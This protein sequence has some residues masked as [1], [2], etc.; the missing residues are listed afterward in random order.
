LIRHALE[1]FRTGAAPAAEAATALAVSR[2]RLHQLH[3]EYLRAYASGAHGE[4]I[5]GVS[6]GDRAPAWPE[7]VVALL[8]RRL[9][10][11]PPSPYAFAASEA[12][13][14]HGFR[15]DRA[16][17]RR[18][19]LAN[20][21]GHRSRPSK[22]PRAPVR[23]W[24]RERVGE[25]WQLDATP[26]AWFPGDPRQYPMLNMLDDCS[27]VFV[28][29][30]LYEREL[31]LSY[32]DFLP[33]AFE[34]HG[35]PLELYVDYHSLFFH[36][37]PESL[38]RLGEMLRFYGVSLRY[39][40]TPQAKGKVEREH[41]YWQ[42]RLP[43]FLAAERIATHAEAN[44]HVDLLRRHR[45][46][47]ETHR[48]LGMTPGAAWDGALQEGRTALR[49]APRCPWWPY[50]W[51]LRKSLLSGDDGRVPVGTCAVRVEVPPRTR[52]VLCR[53]PSGHHSVLAGPPVRGTLPVVLYTSRP[54]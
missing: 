33:A 31:L 7:D 34:E 28:G 17:V 22:R 47:H 2:S 10:S 15:L 14:L 38:T 50:V 21:L 8:R 43:A 6:G 49:T 19:A 3:A 1:A 44:A 27:R 48:E 46:R 23:R 51:S 20:G 42:N 18:W 54:T 53:H 29:S 24:Q 26:H 13:R 5:P 4:W 16:Q 12:L 39:A 40:P 52:V 45:N 32:A 9:S 25:I 11:D 37:D 30:R 36:R 35:L 41:L